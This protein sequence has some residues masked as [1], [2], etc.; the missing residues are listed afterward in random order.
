MPGWWVIGGRWFAG[1]TKEESVRRAF[2]RE[3][4]L[5]LPEGR[6][7]YARLNEYRWPDRQQVPQDKG[8]HSLAFTFLVELTPR[9]RADAWAGLDKAEYISQRGLRPF[10]LH[11]LL[12]EKVHPMLIDLYRQVFP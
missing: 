5:D 1:E 9:E 8:S 6:F 4:K 7:Q 2:K 11:D 12:A 10:N 3:T